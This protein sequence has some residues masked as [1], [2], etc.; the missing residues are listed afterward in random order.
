MVLN[1]RLV[2]SFVDIELTFI[3]GIIFVGVGYELKEH[4]LFGV[5]YLVVCFELLSLHLF[6]LGFVKQLSLTELREFL[7][8]TIH[9]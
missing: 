4:F 6:L 5:V 1:I 7:I 9:W 3:L 8:L 2:F